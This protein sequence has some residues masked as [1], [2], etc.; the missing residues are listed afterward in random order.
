VTRQHGSRYEIPGGGYRPSPG[1]PDTEASASE[2]VAEVR[3]RRHEKDGTVLVFVPGGLYTI[4]TN[5][6][7]EQEKP[8]HRV[9]L[10]PFWIAKVPVTNEQYG[11]FMQANPGYRRPGFWSEELFNRPEQPVVGVSWEDAQAYC[12]WAGLILPSEVQWEAAARGPDSRRYPWGDEPPTPGRANYGGYQGKTTPVGSLEAGR[13]P[14]GTLDQA[15]NVWEWCADVLDAE[16][17]ARRET[18]A[19]DPVVTIGEPAFRVLRG[20][21]WLDKGENLMCA[22]RFRYWARLRR[23]FFGFRCAAADRSEG[24]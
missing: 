17:Y 16:A 5:E 15:G 20:G 4:G 13:G 3:E 9:R 19:L 6:L 8:V 24:S 14:F 18:D 10:S 23:R 2:G 22:Y 7:S 12:N 1:P 11:R 21:S